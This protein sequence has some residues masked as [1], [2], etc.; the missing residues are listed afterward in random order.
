[1]NDLPELPLLSYRPDWETTWDA[2]HARCE[3]LKARVQSPGFGALPGF[4][5]IRLNAEWATV[6]A[7]LSAIYETQF[8][9]T[10][11]YRNWSLYWMAPGL[12]CDP[13]PEFVMPGGL[14]IVEIKR[15]V[16][17]ARKHAR[18]VYK[19]PLDPEWIA[20]INAILDAPPSPEV[21]ALAY[22]LR[23]TGGDRTRDVEHAERAHV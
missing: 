5:Q 18:P 19:A 14:P 3:A 8:A 4:E 13:L 15:R 7:S 9:T 2:A 20:R 22:A 21:Q 1:M 11:A 6:G 23:L 16:G 12:N 10:D 17:E